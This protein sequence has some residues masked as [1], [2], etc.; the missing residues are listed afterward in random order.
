MSK[1]TEYP[2]KLVPT[3]YDETQREEHPEKRPTFDNICALVL[4]TIQP[5]TNACCQTKHADGR[6]G[7]LECQGYHDDGWPCA[8]KGLFRN[9][10]RSGI[11]KANQSGGIIRFGCP[12]CAEEHIEYYLCEKCFWA[13]ETFR[14]RVRADGEQ[15][16]ELF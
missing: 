12:I 7:L 14:G 15:I 4:S 13:K 6:F 5:V 3:L 2:S 1:D 9:G 16:Q 10:C 8:G 11:E